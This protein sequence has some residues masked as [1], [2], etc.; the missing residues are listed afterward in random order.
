MAENNVNNDLRLFAAHIKRAAPDNGL[1]EC[2]V[3]KQRKW[4]VLGLTA[5]SLAI[6]INEGLDSTPIYLESGNTIPTYSILC[7]NCYHILQFAWLPIK[8]QLVTP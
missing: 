4:R 8:N 7:L 3:C 2:N 6:D 5:V 1:P